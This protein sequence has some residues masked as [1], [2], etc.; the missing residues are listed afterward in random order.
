MVG[1]VMMMWMACGGEG[2]VAVVPL[3]APR[4]TSGSVAT[5]EGDVAAVAVA[6]PSNQAPAAE[7]EGWR[8]L[9]PGL[10]L[11]VFTAPRP[12]THGD[13]R[14]T[15]LR[16][17]PA[18]FEPVLLML[19][20][21]R[22]RGET[23]TGWTAREWAARDD[24]VAA[25]NSS[26]FA[27]DFET[28][29]HFM[30]GPSEPGSEGS[31]IHVNNPTMGSGNTLLA[32]DPVEPKGT[33]ALRLFDRGC[34]EDYAVAAAQYRARIQSI[35][36]VDCRRKNVW[37]QQPKQWS[38]AVIG[39]DGAGRLL[40]IHARSP[41]STHDFVDILLGMPIDLARLQ[42]AEGGPE[43]TLYVHAGGVEM[44]RIG[45][46]ETGFYERD[47]NSMAAPLPNVVGIRRR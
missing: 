44:E 27:M 13:S 37:A 12:S 34:G 28:S 45:S 33:P 16:V 21:E 23:G 41:W 22:A 6:T 29:T 32:F 14:V 18:H 2:A 19:S 11:G 35:R 36:M 42:Y 25:I 15:V 24:L 43:A 17:D 40:L 20:A 8:S 47:D 7:I 31:L 39:V 9:E 1:V 46:F 3:A 10:D 4:P 30:V 26:M 5:P 38:H